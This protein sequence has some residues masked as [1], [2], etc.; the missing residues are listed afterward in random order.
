[1]AHVAV[2]DSAE[3]IY[4]AKRDPGCGWPRELGGAVFVAAPVGS[5]AEINAAIGRLKLNF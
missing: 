2:V 4:P 3:Q 5:I 1:M